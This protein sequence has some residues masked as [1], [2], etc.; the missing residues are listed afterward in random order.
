MTVELLPATGYP[1]QES[2]CATL[3]IE[4]DSVIERFFEKHPSF[5]FA[6]LL[7]V[8]RVVEHNLLKRLDG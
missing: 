1:Q 4:I 2:A 5:P 7:G 6:A 3:Q 8:I